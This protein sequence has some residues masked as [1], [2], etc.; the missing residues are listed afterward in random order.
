MPTAALI[1]TMTLICREVAKDVN[2]SR[3]ML[4]YGIQ[5]VRYFRL[6]SRSSYVI[7]DTNDYTFH[8]M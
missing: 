3:L 5:H 6:F 4:Y 7:I 1:L 8:P 2:F